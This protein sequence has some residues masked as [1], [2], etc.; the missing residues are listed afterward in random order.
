M[1]WRH[2][3]GALLAAGG[4]CGGCSFLNG[5]TETVA[6]NTIPA[7]AI[8]FVNG[9]RYEGTPV[10]VTVEKR[11]PLLLTVAPSPSADD[12]A[13]ETLNY[14]VPRN[15]STQ[16]V[17]DL[18]GSVTILPITGLFYPGSRVLETNNIIINLYE[19]PAV[20]D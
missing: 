20:E 6:I 14:V 8:V 5:T 11:H 16:G 3:A 12:L 10:F 15:F 2:L 13:P 1:G 19:P 4:L 17:M 7:N 9:V 18:V